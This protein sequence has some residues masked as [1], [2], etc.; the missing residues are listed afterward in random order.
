[1]GYFPSILCCHPSSE[2]Y[3]YVFVP[4]SPLVLAPLFPPI[5]QI[6]FVENGA[7]TKRQSLLALAFDDL[8]FPLFLSNLPFLPLLYSLFCLMCFFSLPLFL[9]L[10][11]SASLL[12]L[13][14]LFFPFLF[15][16]SLS[17]FFPFRSA[18]EVHIA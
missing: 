12:F 3:L 2:L 8:S 7:K 18:T 17:F 4:L 1:L 6:L 15:F 10:V 9:C 13:F 5:L 11:L 16:C 14:S